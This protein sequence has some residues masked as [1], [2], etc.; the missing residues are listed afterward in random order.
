MPREDLRLL[1]KQERNLRSLMDSMQEFLNEYQAE[2][3]YISLKYRMQKLDEVYDKFIRVRE[4]IEV[5]TDDV[6]MDVGLEGDD[7]Q[8]A[9]ERAMRISEREEVNMRIIKDF[10]NRFFEIKHSLGVLE[11]AESRSCTSVQTVKP[12]T[13]VDSMPRIKLPELKLPTF[14]GKLQD[15]ITF[16]D[17]F[18]SMIHNN[19]HLSDIDKFT[20]LRTSLTDDALIE[21]GSIELTSANYTIAWRTLENTFE[22]RKL[23]VKSY[24]DVLF[25][26]SPMSEESYDQL[27]RVVKD[28]ETTLM[29]LQKVGVETDGMSTILQHMVCQRLDAA[30]LQRWESY[31]NS[32]EVPSYRQLMEFLKSRCL[33]LHNI[34]LVHSVQGEVKR[35][36]RFPAVGHPG[37]QQ[38]VTCP[39]CGESMHSVFKCMKFVKMKVSDRVEV[40]KKRSLCLNCLSS[41]HIA[42]YCLKGSCQNCG[43]RHH[44]LLHAGPPVSQFNSE[45]LRVPQ[46]SNVSANQQPP[47]NETGISYEVFPYSTLQNQT[48]LTHIP[49]PSMNNLPSSSTT[50]NPSTSH[51]SVLSANPTTL[52]N[53]VL[54]STAVLTIGDEYG[55]II[56]ARALLD[57]GSQLCFMTERIAQSLKFHRYREYLPVKGIGQSKTCSTQSV[58][59]SIGSRCSDYRS[60]LKFHVLPK[61]TADIPVKRIDI[62]SWQIP[63]GI[64][65]ADP[66]FQNPGGIDL[67]L[68]AE[69]FYDLLLDG[70]HKLDSIGPILQN[71]QLGWVVSGKVSEKSRV[72]ATVSASCTEERVNELLTRFW[73]LEACHNSSTLS[74]EESEC[75]KIF[76]DTTTRDSS[77]RFVVKLPRKDFLIRLLGESR[78]QAERRFWSLECRLKSNPELKEEYSSF[79]HE[80]L[81]LNHM[82]EVIAEEE[83]DISKPPP[84][85]MPHHHVLRPE[86]STTKLRVVFDASATT[87]SGI[88]LNQALMVGPVLQED[89]VSIVLRF[90]LHRIA[91]VADVAKMYR[92]INVVP[93]DR[94]LQRIV[95]RDSPD[96]PLRTFELT[97][98]TYG[99]ASAPYLATKCLQRLAEC[100]KKKYPIAAKTLSED[101]YMDDCL[102]GADTKEESIKKCCELNALLSSAKMLLRKYNSNNVE[103]L[104]VLPGELR[105][106]RISLELDASQTKIKTLGLIWD[107]QSD[108]FHF[109]VPQ[110]NSSTEI[111]KR[112]ILSDFA[113]LFDPLGLVGP[114]M[115]QA[116][117]FLQELWKQNCSWTETLSN[118]FQQ[119]WLE[120]RSNLAGLSNLQVPRW[121]A[122]GSDVISVELHG[123]CD[124]STKAYGA[125]IYLRCTRSNG[126]ISVNLLISKSRVAPLDD[127]KRKKKKMTIPRLELSSA[128]LLSHLYEKVTGSLRISAK[129]FFWTDSTI[130]KCWL[131]S[132]PSRWQMFVANRVSEIQH[133]TKDG[134]WNHVVGMENP[135]DVLSRGATPEELLNHELWWRG[136]DWL[137][138]S[139][140]AWPKTGGTDET[141]FEHTLLE[142]AAVAGPAQVDSPN[143]IFLLKS[144]FT[145]LVDL[146]AFCRRFSFNC[147][148]RNSHRVGCLTVTEREEALRVLVKLAQKECFPQDISAVD[149][150]GEV[151]N[152]SKLKSLRPQLVNGILVV[153]GRLENAPI[154]VGRKHPIIL[155]NHHPFTL[156][157]VNHYH[158]VMLH[159]GPQ[160]LTACARTCKSKFLC[161]ICQAKHHTM[162]HDPAAPPNEFSPERSQLK[163]VNPGPRGSP[164]PPTINLFVRSNSTV[165]LETVALLVVDRYGIKIPARAQLDSS[166]MSIFITKKLANELATRQSP[167]DIAVAEFGE[168]VMRI[169][170]NLSAKI[171][172]RN[173]DF[174]TTL[175]LVV[176]KKPT[177]YLPTFP[178]DSTAWRIP[179][180]PLAYSQQQST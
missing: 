166:A 16:R 170:C 28:F 15:W 50:D 74:L 87:T 107:T 40:V 77:G 20:Y 26:V 30:T 81:E 105:D 161:G 24:L 175:D 123:F 176:I 61:V 168:A 100:G 159:A 116:K 93:E 101:F 152:T 37:I 165:L 34:S 149:Y 163:Q 179:K 89:L 126:I 137:E 21:I 38:K 55:N 119:W 164:R 96:E 75:E 124:A 135:A 3:D 14:S 95:W 1:V 155:D 72:Q 2:R 6:E 67:I 160:L 99:T 13:A 173:S 114:V 35:Q 120:Y 44:T 150:T 8:S 147:K 133:L 146:V 27:N 134:V 90:R 54:L 136:P 91:I 19:A 25:A 62:G 94:R 22:N 139:H 128:L 82:R 56:P 180:A 141:E 58:F 174:S 4:N 49:N 121:V 178:I 79:I 45:Q 118:P 31:H 143:E 53:T 11:A 104:S 78:S 138:L 106:D 47:Q 39:F 7:E 68:G 33:V 42:R 172:P 48:D 88:S 145:S 60:T 66:E 117:I 171:V 86:S 156:L 71:T 97:T 157:I 125:C 130:V 10:E 80:Y 158:L 92:M 112:I 132:P 140:D 65:M 83:G 64:T 113:R 70:Q 129:C 57:S 151:K 5:I 144:S 108:C 29:M 109:S 76:E 51:S 18:T 102:T 169:K 32:K 52:P 153:G 115:V 9:L 36:S 154:A 59:A 46:Q 69:V 17:T 98:V 131:S 162:L 148:N 73:E 177:S 41:G 12:S 167:V 142:E 63:P 43:R 110:W 84:Y 122:F 85:Y 23:L 127:V 111:N 103:V